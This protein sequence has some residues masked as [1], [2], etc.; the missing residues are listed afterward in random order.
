MKQ[1]S[2]HFTQEMFIRPRRGRPRKANALTVAQRV[3]RHRAKKKEQLIS[4][5]RNEKGLNHG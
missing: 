1:A 4:V 3:A 5:T 2:D